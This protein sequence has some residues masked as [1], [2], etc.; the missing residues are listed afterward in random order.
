[1][2][3]TRMKTCTACAQILPIDSFHQS[4][5]R[6]NGTIVYQPRC[7]SCYNA[8]YATRWHTMD[9]EK[10]A[11]ENFRRKEKFN[12]DWH[13]NYRLTTKYNITL[14]DFQARYEV[15]QGK[16]FICELVVAQDE[17]RVDHCHKS[18]KVRKLLCH[19]CNTLLGHAKEDVN[20]LSKAIDYI[21]DHDVNIQKTQMA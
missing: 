4:S 19:S 12:S 13:K 3:N 17:I 10:K 5:V 20:I 6:K 2:N 14:E 18:G 7:R 1:M 11:K 15:Q 8:H 9:K 16:C 21:K